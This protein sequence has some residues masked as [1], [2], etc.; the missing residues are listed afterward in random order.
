MNIR[1]RRSCTALLALALVVGIISP[2]PA[3]ALSHF[4]SK[5]ATVWGH[6]YAGPAAATVS[7]RVPK[8]VFLEKKSKFVVKYNNFPDWAKIDFQSAVDVWAENFSSSVPITIDA[9]WGRQAS[10]GVLGSARP[11]SY[12]AGFDGA[13]DQSLWYPSALA[14][15]VAGRDLDPAN[16]EIIIRVNSLAD[17]NPRNDGAPTKSEYDLESVFIHELGHGLGFLST[18]S[19]DPHLGFG[20]IEEPTPY[21]AY[22]Q[23]P[24]GKRL[25]DLP[26]PSVELGTA[27]TSPLVWSGTLGIKA[28]GGV[29]PLLYS[30]GKYEDGSSISHLDEATFS[31]AGLDSVMTPNLSAGEV[32]HGPGPL[33][34]AMMQD[35]RLKPPAGIAVGIPQLVRRA[36]ALVSDGSAIV[37]FDPPANA[38]SAQITSYTV[39]NLKTGAEKSTAKS[40]LLFEGLKN[41]TSYTFSIIAH[42][43]N[44]A[45]EPLQTAAVIPQQGWKRSVIDTSS[46]GQHLTSATFN[47]QPV[48]AYTDSKSGRLKIALWNGKLWKKITVDGSGGTNGRTSNAINSPLSLCVNGAGIKQTLHIFYSDAVDKDLRHAAYDGKNFTFEVVDGNGA[49]VN[50]YQDPVR[51]RTASDVSISSACVA[52]AS[53]IQLFYRDESQGILLGATKLRGASKW[54]YELVDGDRAT[55]GRTTGDIGFHLKALFD[56]GKTYVIYDSVLT[57]NARKDATSGAV[58]IATRTTSNPAEWKY[59][60]LDSSGGPTAM[61]G[62][63]VGLIKTR[64]GILATWLASTTTSLPN[65][66]QVRQAIISTTPNITTVTT[67]SYGTPS[68]YLNS[69]GK[70]TVFNCQER[71]CA[72]DLTDGDASDGK[73]R[74]IAKEQNPNGI[75]TAWV[76]ANRVRYLVA[77]IDNKLN[78]L[79]P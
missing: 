6:V 65:P 78:L 55:G 38:R 77:G 17:W 73:T 59:L 74:L 53:G 61:T 67:E 44:G 21:D 19:Y 8:F 12:F 75:E 33:L 63:A 42:N 46:D 23:T 36:V 35:M 54:S 15:A 39:K 62:Y 2:P 50:L 49:Q 48:I 66:N 58:R 14:N 22:A 24:D 10:F 79:R 72:F 37:R 5:P 9:V 25:S 40:P 47:G 69:D 28:N 11:G 52:S 7:K 27:L 3:V 43:A 57:L 56:G 60:S 45:S 71:L 13:P 64:R 26:S 31:N 70:L 51:V 20:S 18:D 1:L 30:P 29:K 41:G 76:V 16:P 32:F 68:K 4:R 34:L